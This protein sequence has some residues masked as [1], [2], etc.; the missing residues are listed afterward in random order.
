MERVSAGRG[1]SW[2][3]GGWRL[4]RMKPGAVIGSVLLMYVLLF[5]AQMLPFIGGILAMVA[6][7]FLSGG[8]YLML[9]RVRR[10]AVEAEDEPLAREQPVSFDLLF[11][12][13]KQP[14]KRRPLLGL[15]A[16]ALLFNLAML[17]LFAIFVS[18]NLGGVDHNLLTDPSTTDQ[19]KMRLLLPHLFAPESMWLWLIVLALSVAYAMATLFAVP[20][21]VLDGAGLA[22][23]LKQ[24]FRAVG[25]NWLPFLTYGLIWMLLSFFVVLSFGLALIVLA[26]LAFASIYIAFR[27]IWPEP[28][29]ENDGG[30]QEPPVNPPRER[31]STVM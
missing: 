8:V 18:T 22:E 1:L 31:S 15:A 3:Q 25:Q 7:P 4:L 11:S 21:I 30:S 23:A 5:V 13:F 12:L 29:Q 9:Q 28:E 19:E 6:A 2:I 26:P 10:I 27:D 24:S 17:V 14:E 20:Q 16:A